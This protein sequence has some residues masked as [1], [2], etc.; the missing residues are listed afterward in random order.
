MKSNTLGDWI[1]FNPFSQT[2][3]GPLTLNFRPWEG[4]PHEPHEFI[5]RQQEVARVDH[6]SSTKKI[7]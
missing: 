7:Q 4:Q 1:N 2:A 5:L 6:Y 3:A